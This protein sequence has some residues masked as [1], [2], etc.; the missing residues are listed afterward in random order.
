[1]LVMSAEFGDD[2]VMSCTSGGGERAAF[3]CACVRVHIVFLLVQFGVD[4]L[5]MSKE[6]ERLLNV[7]WSVCLIFGFHL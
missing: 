6:R 5:C 3:T 1:M 4:L 2:S 7:F